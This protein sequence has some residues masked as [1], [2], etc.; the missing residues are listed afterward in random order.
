MIE[1]RDAMNEEFIQLNELLEQIISGLVIEMP[2]ACPACTSLRPSLHVYFNLRPNKRGG[3]WI[4]CSNCGVYFHGSI[5]PPEWWSNLER[6]D[7]HR[8][9]SQPQYLDTHAEEIDSHW[10]DLINRGKMQK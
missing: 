7:P 8:L 1:W 9:A 6:L 2:T 5:T 4:W 10:N 3:V